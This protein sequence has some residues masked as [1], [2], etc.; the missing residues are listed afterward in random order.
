M[1]QAEAE[2][3]VALKSLDQVKA[4]EKAGSI[5]AQAAVV[6]RLEDE[7]KT[8]NLF[9]KRDKDLSA[10]NVISENDLE[11]SRLNWS[12]AQKNYEQGTNFLT[13]IREVRP[14]DVGLAEAKVLAAR[15]SVQRAQAELEL[16]TIR[17]PISSSRG[18]HRRDR[19]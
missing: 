18:P 13:A 15:A 17:A 5:A 1:R 7:L 19:R 3:E 11:R 8:A 10:R 12:V 16:A 14:V 4:G 2:L 6:L 9:F